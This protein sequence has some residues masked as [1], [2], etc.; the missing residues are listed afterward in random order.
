MFQNDYLWTRQNKNIKVPNYNSCGLLV[1]LTTSE[2]RACNRFES[3]HRHL[4]PIVTIRQIPLPC[5]RLILFKINEIH[6]IW[7]ALAYPY[8]VYEL[9]FLNKKYPPHPMF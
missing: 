3:Q 7:L 9:S 8:S 5:V 2:S 4:Q 6:N 1:I